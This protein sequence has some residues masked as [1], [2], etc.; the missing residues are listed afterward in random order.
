[1]TSSTRPRIARFAAAGAVALLAAALLTE[2]TRGQDAPGPPDFA[3]FYGTVQDGGENIAPEDQTL[4]ALIDGQAC[5]TV[6]TSVAEAIPG[7]PAETIGKTVYAIHVM[8]D[9][10]GLF[11][12]PGCGTTGVDVRFYFPETHRLAQQVGTFT[13]VETGAWTELNLT[14]GTELS[15]TLALPLMARDTTP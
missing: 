9:G 2:T 8:A 7:N 1:M 5:G 14:L 13:S 3:L 4:L 15:H 10:T 6:E 11:Q 12:M